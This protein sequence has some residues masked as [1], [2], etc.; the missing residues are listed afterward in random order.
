MQINYNISDIS[1]ISGISKLIEESKHADK[2]WLNKDL[3][4]DS[5][6]V[7]LRRKTMAHVLKDKHR[8]LNNIKSDVKKIRPD[9]YRDQV[10]EKKTQEIKDIQKTGKIPA[11]K[12]SKKLEEAGKPAGLVK[13]GIATV[14]TAGG[15]LGLMQGAKALN[16][17]IQG[18][19]SHKLTSNLED[20]MNQ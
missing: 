19:L 3:S 16:K 10:I 11:P 7:K 15:A 18:S 13:T 2:S 5:D 8:I 17:G 20:M 4:K 9:F 12:S 6:D 1:G 14:G